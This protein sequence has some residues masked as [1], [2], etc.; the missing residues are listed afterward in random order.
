MFI[1]YVIAPALAGLAG[2]VYLTR[3]LGSTR[4]HR[5]SSVMV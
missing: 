2:L 1:A 5:E 3:R 4:T